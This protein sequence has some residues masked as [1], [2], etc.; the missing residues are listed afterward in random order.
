[1]KM[2]ELISRLQAEVESF[3]DRDVVGDIGWYSDLREGSSE[4]KATIIICAEY[5]DTAIRDKYMFDG[6]VETVLQ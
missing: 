2:S 5:E 6:N 1:M 4:R 3:G